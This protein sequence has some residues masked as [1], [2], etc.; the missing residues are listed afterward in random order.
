MLG[1]GGADELGGT[2]G[3][4]HVGLDDVAR[5]IIVFGEFGG[6]FFGAAFGGVGCVV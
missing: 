5:D 1:F 6:E 2:R 3:G 4:A